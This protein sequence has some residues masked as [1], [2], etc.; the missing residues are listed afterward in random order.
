MICSGIHAVTG[1]SI[2]V[3]FDR[4]IH[5]ARPTQASLDAPYLAPGFVDL[6]INGFAGVD[7]NDPNASLEDI[8]RALDA[9][10]ATGVTR[11]LPTV[12]TGSPDAMC[13]S[14]RN[15]AR[16]RHGA[17]AGFHIEGPHIGPDDGPRGAHPAR[18][19]RPPDLDEFARMQDAADGRIRLATVS[20]H[21]PE[22]PRYI[23]ALVNAG[24]TVAIGHTGANK[25]QI[26]AAVDAGATLS[27]HLGNAAPS[28]LPKFPNLLLDQLAEDRL[29][30]GFI[31]DGLH[32][33]DAFLRVAVRAKGPARTVL[34]TDAAAP[35]GMAPG[36]YR[37]GELDVDLTADD[38]VVLAGTSKLAGSALRMDRAIANLMRIAQVPLNGAISA[39]TTNPARLIR[40]QGLTNGLA[41]GD[42]ADLVVFRT[43]P[44]RIEAVYLNGERVV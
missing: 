6:Q 16:V 8:G 3:E 14:L 5:S 30:A 22:S 7:F 37:L 23:A 44:M 4:V 11:C 29:T 9:I 41:P 28:P 31:A 42:C 35:A 25:T 20:P 40:L 33:D 10:L 1:E 26:A 38:R 36:S 12:I 27:T 43:L 13:A 18:W 39:V 21:W 24:V 32:L 17:I 19:V 2:A 15:L 34:V